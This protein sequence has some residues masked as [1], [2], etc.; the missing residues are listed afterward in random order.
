MTLLSIL[1]ICLAKKHNQSHLLARSSHGPRTYEP[2]AW[3]KPHCTVVIGDVVIGHVNID[4]VL[5]KLRKRS[6]WLA[7]W[8]AGWQRI[9]Y[10][11]IIM[12]PDRLNLLC[13]LLLTT[14]DADRRRDTLAMDAIQSM[15]VRSLH[16][17][18][19]RATLSR[20]V[21]CVCRVLAS[22]SHSSRLPVTVHPRL[23]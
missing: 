5:I 12:Q 18:A 19:R 14:C 15:L 6:G 4:H 3:F 16:V 13:R 8:L 23:C 1:R 22:C 9:N 17:R 2:G 20:C 7:G 21:V 10:T 11:F